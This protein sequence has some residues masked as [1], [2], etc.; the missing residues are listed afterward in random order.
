MAYYY[1][2]IITGTVFHPIR[3]KKKSSDDICF[4][5]GYKPSG[6]EMKV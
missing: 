6:V 2:I 3:G 5:K 4:L 1:I